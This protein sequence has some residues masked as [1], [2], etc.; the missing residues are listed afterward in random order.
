MTTPEI[1]V[2]MSVFNDAQTL[3]MTLESVLNQQRCRFEFIVVDD[4]S[5]DSSEEILD[6]W[7]RRD[8]RLKVVHQANT[9]L[10]RALIRGCAQARG[11]FIARQDA[12]DISIP[13][14][15][16]AQANRLRSD[17]DCVA[18]SCHADF[19][20]PRNEFLYRIT[21]TEDAL[22]RGVAGLNGPVSGPAHHG[23]VMMKAD[24]YRLTGGYRSAFYFSQDLD[25]WTRMV[26][27]GRFGVV[28]D[29]LYRARL[30]PGSISGMRSREQRQLA[31]LVARLA[32]AR[33]SGDDESGLLAEAMR[34]TPDKKKDVGLRLAQGNYF[35]GSC[36]RKT[37]SENARAYFQEALRHD[38]WHW[39][40]RIRLLQAKTG[41]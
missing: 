17:P 9:G 11:T 26:E 32:V 18:V 2:V 3:A 33:R 25:L 35:I 23:S 24:V 31:R 12:G 19:V 16:A 4:G 39:R 1:S 13:G 37:S 21:S 8:G 6:T 27:H 36:L 5:T 20:G 38:P 29:V 14:R 28:D 15:L 34:V 41:F 22:N 30:C 7:A 10:T 40:A